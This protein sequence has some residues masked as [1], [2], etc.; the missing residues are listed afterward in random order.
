MAARCNA[1]PK[2]T[3][4]IC[5]HGPKS[6]YFGVPMQFLNAPDQ[7]TDEDLAQGAAAWAAALDSPFTV[8]EDWGWRSVGPMEYIWTRRLLKSVIARLIKV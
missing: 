1:S 8:D 4:P 2:T 7:T 5:G 6:D 3:I